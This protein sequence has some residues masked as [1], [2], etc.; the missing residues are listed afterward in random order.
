M[1][2]CRIT[3]FSEIMEHLSSFPSQLNLQDQGLFAI[4]YYHQKNALYRKKEANIEEGESN[5]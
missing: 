2:T 4:A 3:V 5:E 1:D